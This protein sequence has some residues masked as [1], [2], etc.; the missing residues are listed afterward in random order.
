MKI[1]VDTHSHTVASTHAYSTV[2]DY[3]AQAKLK[4]MQMFS[5]TDHAPEMPDSPH[6][7]HFGNMQIIPRVVD[8]VAMLRG[9]EGNIMPMEGGLDVSERMQP[10]LDFVIASFHEPVFEPVDKATHTKAMINTIESGT[11]HI[12]GHPGNP[13]YPLDYEEVVRAA[14][15]NNVLVEINNSSFSHSRLGSE[16]F[17]LQILELVDK[18]DWKVVFSSDAHIAYHVGDVTHCVAKAEKVG[19]PIERVINRD[20]KTFLGFLSEHG[21]KVEQELSDWLQT[22]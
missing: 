11:C 16:E 9:I 1:L 5:I 20:A 12:L 6:P 14:R 10:F 3:F 8:G 13:N 17:C 19:F 22:L 15:D 4:G 18:L 2:H 21:K 7:W